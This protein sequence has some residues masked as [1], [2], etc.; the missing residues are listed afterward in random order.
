MKKILFLTLS[1]L[2]F[3]LPA[4]AV[5]NYSVG[6]GPVGNIFVVDARP[7]LDPGVGGQVYFDYRWSPQFS[8]QFGVTIS[9]QDGTGSSSGDDGILFIGMPTF[10]LKFFLF[11]TKSRF[12]PYG[13]IGLGVYA[14]TE[15]SRS[16]AS[17]AIG[18]GADLG[19]GCDYYINENISVGLS[20]IYRSIGLIDKTSG[21]NNGTALFP[22]TLGGAVAWHW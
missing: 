11:N 21:S 1:L 17:T 14:V 3:S 15:G 2:S 19:L 6:F 10:D 16:N 12:D 4:W 8:T 7:E 5:G 13:L 9:T 18:V 22:F 20:A